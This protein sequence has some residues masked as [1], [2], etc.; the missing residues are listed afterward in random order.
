MF[1]LVGKKRGCIITCI[2]DASSCGKNSY[3]LFSLMDDMVVKLGEENIVHIVIENEPSCKI[4]DNMLI[5][6]EDILGI[7]CSTLCCYHVR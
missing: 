7:A 5:K 3:Y 6:K 4:G 1:Y 2:V